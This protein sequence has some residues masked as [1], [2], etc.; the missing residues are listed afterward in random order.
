MKRELD[1][2]CVNW[3]FNGHY[4][5]L[6][7]EFIY[8]KHSVLFHWPSGKEVAFLFTE[9]ISGNLNKAQLQLFSES[10]IDGN[11][12][13]SKLAATVMILIL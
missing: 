6:K 3:P 13:A 11:L 4:R 5:V 10:I 12:H 1:T 2:A 7:A 8:K 9:N